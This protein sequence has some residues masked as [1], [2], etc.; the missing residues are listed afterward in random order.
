MR[1]FIGVTAGIFTGDEQRE[2][3]LGMA[4]AGIRP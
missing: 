1:L 2:R 4:L 3:V